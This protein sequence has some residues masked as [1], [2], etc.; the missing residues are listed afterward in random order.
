MDVLSCYY[1]CLSVWIMGFM[2]VLGDYT[3]S[4]VLQVCYKVHR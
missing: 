3:D 1:Y 4:K 2:I